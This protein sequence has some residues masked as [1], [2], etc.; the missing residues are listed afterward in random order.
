MEVTLGHLIKGW[1]GNL[2]EQNLANITL[3]LYLEIV[4][5]MSVVNWHLSCDNHE[6]VHIL[7]EII[8][9]FCFMAW[10]SKYILT[11]FKHVINI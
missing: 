9:F 10:Q 7:S 8:T 6:M 3:K 1:Y 11:Q 5:H 2:H 4:S